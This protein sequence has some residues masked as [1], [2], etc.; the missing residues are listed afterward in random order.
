MLIV[1]ITFHQIILHVSNNLN[2]Y[3]LRILKKIILWSEQIILNLILNALFYYENIIIAITR[4]T[5]S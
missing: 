3:L 4:S 1:A 5:K 2:P